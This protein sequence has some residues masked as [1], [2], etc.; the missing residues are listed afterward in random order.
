MA[1]FHHPGAVDGRLFGLHS[2]RTA[3]YRIKPEVNECRKV[4]HF[5]CPRRSK[6]TAFNF[7]KCRY[8][9]GKLRYK[10]IP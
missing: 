6:F 2:G 8:N 5:V 10:P 7:V 3:R 4:R 1:V 9:I